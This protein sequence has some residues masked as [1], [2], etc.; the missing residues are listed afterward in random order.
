MKYPYNVN[1][2][3]RKQ[4]EAMMSRGWR[5]VL[6]KDFNEQVNGDALYTRL[7]EQGYKQ[8]KVYYDTT[9]VKGLHENFAF[10]K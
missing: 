4:Q 9:A 6:A 7:V 2:C 1:Y 5:L 3:G 10:V 8:V